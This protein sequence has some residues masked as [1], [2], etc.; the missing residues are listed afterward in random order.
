MNPI[1]WFSLMMSSSIS[2]F[3]FD[4]LESFSLRLVLFSSF[5]FYFYFSFY[6]AL[7]ASSSSLTALSALTSS[8]L[9]FSD[10]PSCFS[11]MALISYNFS[12]LISTSAF[13]LYI[14]STM[15][16]LDSSS[17][18]SCVTIPN[19][20]SRYCTRYMSMVISVIE[21]LEDLGEEV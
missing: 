2:S 20:F 4:V 15:S 10:L 17:I 16:F 7:S 3:V 14:L 19:Y 13:S 9:F 5:S 1:S 8:S 18:S 11:S 12:R 21:F 6:L